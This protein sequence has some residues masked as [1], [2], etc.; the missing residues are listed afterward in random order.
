[1]DGEGLF[2]STRVSNFLLYYYSARY[3]TRACLNNLPTDRKFL[4][5]ASTGHKVNGQKLKTFDTF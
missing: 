5:K 4:M 3:N 2:M 1:M